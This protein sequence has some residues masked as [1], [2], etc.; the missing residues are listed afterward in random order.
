MAS[1]AQIF[2]N[3]ANA[4]HSSGPITDEGKAR[5]AQNRLTHGLAGTFSLMTWECPDQFQEFAN[6]IRT[7]NNPQTSEENRLVASMIQHYWLMQRALTLQGMLL[8]KDPLDDN[9]QKKIALYMRYQT[10]NER[11]YYKARKELQTLRK[12]KRTEEIG[13]ESQKRKAAEAEAAEVRKQE[14]HAARVRLTN[15]RAE[16]AE[17]E[18]EVRLTVE[19]PLPGNTRIA[20]ADIQNACAAA[21]RALAEEFQQKAAA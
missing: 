5:V 2:A 13:F 20:F 16:D 3:Q 11:S 9:N 10:T 19:A 15:A 1:P 6:E 21:V 7:E 12:Q 4:Q 17:I 18:N 8:E 14:A